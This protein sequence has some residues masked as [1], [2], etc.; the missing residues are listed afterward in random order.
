MKRAFLGDSYDIVKRMWHELL[1]EWAPLYAESR[2]I[3]EELRNDYEKLTKISILDDQHPP[4]YSILN[5][6]CTGIRLPTE[7][8][9]SE[10][11]THVSLG[12]IIEQLK[13]GAQ[14]VITFDQSNYRKIGKLNEQHQTKMKWLAKAGYHSFYYVSHAPF[15]FAF[16]NKEAL[17]KAEKILKEAG[18]PKNRIV[19]I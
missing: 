19:K 4:I 13:D 16:P 10:G 6:P 7:Q 5:D 12:T 18:I 1:A 9:Q 8:N 14:C 15:L 3:P 17:L 2:F 11:Q